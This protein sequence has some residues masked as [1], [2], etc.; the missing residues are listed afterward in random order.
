MKMIKRLVGILAAA[1]L[2][3]GAIA[4]EPLKAAFVYLGPVG[5]G[6]WT[7]AHDQG[8]AAMVKKLGDKVQAT[9]VENV[10]ESADAE[11][12]LRDLAT[13]GNKV[14][15]TTSFGYMDSTLKVAK[16]FPKVEFYHATGFKSSTNVT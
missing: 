13:K 3:G 7:Y 6:G 2:C 4:A 10:P 5:D 8:R 16:S 9:I 12:V 14:I 1:A 11:R 15:F